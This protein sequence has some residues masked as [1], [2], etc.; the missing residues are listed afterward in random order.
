MV[1]LTKSDKPPIK[2]RDLRSRKI[3]HHSHSHLIFI[4]HPVINK[5]VATHFDGYFKSGIVQNA[6][7]GN[8]E[9]CVLIVFHILKFT[10]SLEES[11][12]GPNYIF[13]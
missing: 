8:S 10:I 5:V 1:V 3:S 7:C 2:R 4:S 11:E 13:C 9:D 6:W 12:S